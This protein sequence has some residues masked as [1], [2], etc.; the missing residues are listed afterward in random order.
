[1]A[2]AALL[3]GRARKVT[4]AVV[5][6]MER[7]LPGCTVLVSGDLEQARRH[8]RT[9]IAEKPEVVLSGGGDGA[10]IHLLNLWREEG[11]GPFPEVGIL[12]LGTGNGWARALGAPEFFKHVK[13]LRGLKGPLPSQQFDLVET[14]GHLCHFAGVG[15]DA[16]IINDYQRN[17]DKR[18]AQ[19]IGSRFASW[20]HKGVRGY[21]YSVARLTIPE[22]AM[23]LYRQ[24]QPEVVLEVEKGSDAYTLDETGQPTKLP[25]AHRLY[26]GPVSIG[27]ASTTPEFGYGVR[28][29][30]FCQAVPGHI[31]VRIYAQ[32]V[33]QAV[34][35]APRLW[36]GAWPQKGMYDWFAKSVR[37]RFSRPMPF[38]IGGDPMGER[39]EIALAVARE[40]VRVVDWHALQ[41]S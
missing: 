9:L 17:L 23:L 5:R 26:E 21:L 24:G 11:G 15:W 7:A 31:N 20:L 4:P 12:R 3:N 41:G 35:N 30:P 16:R 13:R 28:A 32:S 2:I 8:V 19:L 38:Q 33:L 29:F 27:A 40:T 22:E 10:V 25:G 6:A 34:R 1:M 14:E 18:S 36:R 39:E 37:M